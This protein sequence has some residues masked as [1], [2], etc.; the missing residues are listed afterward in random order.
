MRTASSYPS[1]QSSFTDLPPDAP[2]TETATDDQESDT[3]AS[4]SAADTSL[5]NCSYTPTETYSPV[6]QSPTS[7]L[8][9]EVTSSKSDSSPSFLP[10]DSSDNQCDTLSPVSSSSTSHSKMD[11]L[12]S[13][14]HLF[15]PLYPG[16]EVTLCGA[17]CAIMV[18]WT[19]YKLP[20][21][22]IAG[23]LKLLGVLCPT[24]N[25]LSSSFYAIKIFFQQ[26]NSVHDH[27]VL[28]SNCFT[29]SCS[30]TKRHT[31]CLVH[32]DIQKPLERIV[33]GT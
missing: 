6:N 23:L 16:A 29:C 28:C 30:C 18:F 25:Y 19:K 12:I 14:S 20:Y 3:T 21:I 13:D 9:A 1:T 17:V 33:S 27:E 15:E 32:L 10:T 26:F 8:S 31:A 11:D 4:S 7:P 2:N 22:A 5:A 24:P